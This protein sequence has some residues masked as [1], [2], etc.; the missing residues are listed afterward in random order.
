VTCYSQQELYTV[1]NALCG[2][3][4]SD[5]IIRLSAACEMLSYWIV[6]LSPWMKTWLMFWQEKQAHLIMC[7]QWM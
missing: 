5:W 6:G 2:V 1:T 3:L 4:V 7:R